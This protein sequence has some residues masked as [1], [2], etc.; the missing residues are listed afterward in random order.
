MEKLTFGLSYYSCIVSSAIQA[1]GSVISSAIGAI[2]GAS[3]AKKEREFNAKEAE[4][5]RDWQTAEREATQ[6]FNL[7]MWNKNNEYNS[8][9]SQIERAKEAGVNP[10]SII[11][12]GT[13]TPIANPVVSQAGA[14]SQ[15]SVSGSYAPALANNI[16]NIGLNTAQSLQALANARLTDWQTNFYKKTEQQRI[17]LI[18]QEFD[19]NEAQIMSWVAD[20]GLKDANAS[21]VRESMRYIGRMNEAQLKE[22]EAKFAVYQN[23]AKKLESEFNLNN[24]KIETEKANTEL[25]GAQA[26]KV[27]YEA[28]SAEYQAMQDKLK[29]DLANELGISA[30]S[31][32]YQILLKMSK[33]N[34]LDEYIDKVITRPERGKWKPNDYVEDSEASISLGFLGKVGVVGRRRHDLP[35]SSRNPSIQEAATSNLERYGFTD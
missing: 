19:K 3:Q 35:R 33:E 6:E 12:G 28:K 18:D 32:E 26:D 25:V 8:L 10:N 30:D 21:S 20:A 2:A 11:S 15:A 29:F 22:I 17:K 9:S 16:S 23:E 4:K 13:T 24:V 14:G 7:D 5:N 31:P 1:G 27:G 34:K